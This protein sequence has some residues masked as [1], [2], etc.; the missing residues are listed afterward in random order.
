MDGYPLGCKTQRGDSK[1][2]QKGS[3][4]QPIG[5]MRLV[6]AKSMRSLYRAPLAAAVAQHHDHGWCLMPIGFRFVEF[7]R[8]VRIV[9]YLV[10]GVPQVVLP[11]LLHPK[12]KVGIV[13]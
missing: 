8:F 6:A 1:M 3:I 10:G 4:G 9:L 7:E 2:N 12:N 11:L 5:E 13:F